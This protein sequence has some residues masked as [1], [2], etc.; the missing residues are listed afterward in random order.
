[1]L[2]SLGTPMLQMGDERGRSQ[3]GNNNAYCQ[4]G[5]AVW[6]DW[7]GLRP[8]DE[9]LRRLVERLV[10]LRRRHPAF[11]RRS[12]FRGAA[13]PAGV[14]DI[15]WLL[16]EGREP[17]PSDW[18]D[19][20][21]RCLGYLLAGASESRAGRAESLLVLMNADRADLAF[22]LSPLPAGSAWEVLLD[23]ATV[24]DQSTARRLFSAGEAFPLKAHSLAL[25]VGP[26]G[27]EPRRSGR[28]Q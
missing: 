8:A 6:V 1:L 24:G 27:A 14:K 12:F 21:R 22:R 18:G 2:L 11:A 4:D 20:A 23:T 28:I 9:A 3:R 16:P 17:G 26:A 19:R 7:E 13:T 10:A 25:L 5:P 15:T